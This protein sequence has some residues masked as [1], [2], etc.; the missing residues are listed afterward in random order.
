MLQTGAGGRVDMPGCPHQ[1]RKTYG[2]SKGVFVMRKLLTGIALAA[3]LLLPVVGVG[4]GAKE[5]EEQPSGRPR[6]TSETRAS[7]TSS[8]AE[9]E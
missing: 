1:T 7:D 9:A 4:C 6:K 2:L 3:L 5:K 8:V